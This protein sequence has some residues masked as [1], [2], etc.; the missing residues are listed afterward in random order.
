MNQTVGARNLPRGLAILLCGALALPAALGQD[1]PAARSAPAKLRGFSGT[2]TAAELSDEDGFARL[3]SASRLEAT[4]RR[5]TEE[6]HLAGTDAS[7]RVAEYLRDEYRAAGLEAELV[8]YR[9]TLSYPGETLLE[10]TAP[11]SMRL[12]RPELP[13]D[14]DPSSADLR[15]IPA[16]TAYSPPGEVKGQVVYAN[17]GLPEDFQRLAEMGIDVRGKI[18]LVR[19]G[20]CFRGVK[21]H[22]GEEHGASAVLLYSDPAD[23]GYRAGDPY[24]NG[25]WRPESG[26]ERGSVQY[27]FLFPGDP[28]SAPGAASTA[29]M[30]KGLESRGDLNL[31]RIPSLPISWRDAAE[32]LS[33]LRGHRAPRDWQGGMPFPYHVGPGPT[34]AHLKLAMQL[35]VRTIYDVIALLPGETPDWVLAGNHHDA[36]VFGAADPGSGTAVLLELARSLG[37]MKRN[38][39]TPRRTIVFCSWD[40]E[41]F[42]LVGSTAWVEQH[43]EE[44]ARKGIA[45]LNMDIAVLGERFGGAAT[46][47]LRELVREVARDTT[48]PRTSKS[49]YE[50]WRER[51]AQY[52]SAQRTKGS[53]PGIAERPLPMSAMGSGSDYSAFYQHA[54]I[55]SLD[56]SS[57]GEYGVYHSIYDDFNWMKR[58]GDPD[59]SYHVMMT[60]ISG[61]IVMRL[62]DADVPAFDYAEYGAEVNRLLGDLRAFVRAA[63]AR[64]VRLL[65][66]RGAEAAAAIFQTEAGKTDEAIRGMLAN[67]PDAHQSAEMTRVLVQVETALLSPQ[68][69]TGRPWYR[70][71]F[72]APGI[73]TGYTAV[74]FP[75]VRDAVEHRDWP[76]ARREAQALQDALERATERLREAAK[77]A[78]RSS[79]PHP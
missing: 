28:F 68:G 72:S 16:Y 44:L 22:L 43:S 20:Q 40:A 79:A 5:L 74:T 78:S 24:P 35:E 2:R 62:A 65:D 34:E 71:T 1:R 42:G 45:Y 19:Y 26:I 13:V 38:G 33:Y 32:L 61:R 15:A 57:S 58:F 51:T 70:H 10:R 60:Q 77:L 66:L 3:P 11:S 46:P 63:G 55:P 41:E 53:R 29:E 49:V 31:P 69:L 18:L 76:A 36:W 75:G 27:T 8:P 4:L 21:V 67:S 48:D 39:W 59:F 52:A 50:R 30:P 56:I 7:R 64:D 9:V 17:Y 14:G 73:N 6:P 25:P 12:A 47:S 37:A 54:G 23:D